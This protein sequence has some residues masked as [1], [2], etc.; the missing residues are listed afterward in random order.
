L[1]RVLGD[2][3]AQVFADLHREHEVDFHLKSGVRE[4]R[5][6]GSVET[7]VLEDGTELPADVVVAGV[8]IRPATELAEAAG[9]TVDNGVRV[10]AALRTADPDVYAAG[11][12]ARADHP[13]YADPVRVEHWANALDGG[14]VAAKSM[15]GQ[16]VTFDKIPYFFSDQYDLGMEYSGYV[17]PE[18]YDEVVFRGDVKGREFLAF[19]VGGGK[20]LA[21]MN[22]NIWDVT[23]PIV[24]AIRSGAPVDRA[25]LADPS[26][27]LE[28]LA[29]YPRD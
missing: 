8:G 14:P 2:E 23:D 16:P 17:G 28:D 22:V 21:G 11:D 6:S 5:G 4:I 24:A 29:G 27:P 12:V 1:R 3:V 26:V 10:D 15:L 25:R 20:L 18:G 19:W 9:L 7:V 13:L